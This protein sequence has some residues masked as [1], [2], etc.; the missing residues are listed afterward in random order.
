MAH[1]N[2]GG[3]WFVDEVLKQ[4]KIIE[5]TTLMREQILI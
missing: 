3:L 1:D 5:E 4:S 2:M